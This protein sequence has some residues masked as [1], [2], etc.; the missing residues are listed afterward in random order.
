MIEIIAHRGASR[1][2]YEN[3]LSAFQRAL[4]LGADG[5]E[6][7]VHCTSDGTVMVHHDAIVRGTVPDAA[8]AGR[9]IRALTRA[10]V[11]AFRLPDGSA[12]PTLADVATLLGSRATLYC[13]LK[14]AGTAEPAAAVLRASGVRCA[15]HS[16]DHRMVAAAA[17]AA[18]DIPRGVLEVS[19][20]LD[21]AAILRSVHARDLWQLVEYMDETLVSEV[22]AAGGRVVAWTGN[23]P[24]VLER[25]A[26]WGVDALCTDDVAQAR[27]VLGR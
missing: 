3:T 16:F 14:G 27:R 18:P 1:E 19:R 24:Q 9:P 26:Q 5:V 20:H 12:V 2:C 23:D 11:A 8:L 21:S 6:L 17:V 13:E 10:E 15:V 4:D 7:D 25:L 22:H